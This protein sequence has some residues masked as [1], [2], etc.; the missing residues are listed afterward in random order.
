M[1]TKIPNLDKPPN[2]KKT[3]IFRKKSVKL[4]IWAFDGKV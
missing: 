2:I 3:L 1:I 4:P